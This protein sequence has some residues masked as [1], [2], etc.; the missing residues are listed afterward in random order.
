[1][2]LLGIDCIYFEPKQCLRPAV[3]SARRYS[4]HPTLNLILWALIL[5]LLP[6]TVNNSTGFCETTCSSQPLSQCSLQD[7]SPSCFG[8]KFSSK[9]QTHRQPPTPQKR[10]NEPKL[11]VEQCSEN[12]F[13]SILKWS[14]LITLHSLPRTSYSWAGKT[15]SCCQL[16]SINSTWMRLLKSIDIRKLYSLCEVKILCFAQSDHDVCVSLWHEMIII[17]PI[18]LWRHW[19]WFCS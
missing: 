1:M 3:K 16:Y 14:S 9:A 2:H 15:V 18:L 17:V 19:S 8:T 5:V 6:S 10:T 4:F 11:K 13:L 12:E 7:H